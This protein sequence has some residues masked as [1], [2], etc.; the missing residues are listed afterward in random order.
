MLEGTEEDIDCTKFLG[1]EHIYT[2]AV[3]DTCSELAPAFSYS[4]ELKLLS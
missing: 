1:S 4:Y 2:F 3:L